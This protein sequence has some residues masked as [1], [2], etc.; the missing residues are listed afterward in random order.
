[1]L[2]TAKIALWAGVILLPG[3]MLLLPVLYAV[4]RNGARTNPAPQPA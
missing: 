3:G 2:L 4:H 1:M